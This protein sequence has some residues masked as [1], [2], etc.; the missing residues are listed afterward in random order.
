MFPDHPIRAL[1]L[2][3]MGGL[4]AAQNE[5][6]VR[7]PSGTRVF[8]HSRGDRGAQPFLEAW[9]EADAIYFREGASGKW[10]TSAFNIVSELGWRAPS[11]VEG[12][13]GVIKRRQGEWW[14]LRVNQGHLPHQRASE[15][16]RFDPGPKTWLLHQ[17]LEVQ[18][19]N[20]EVFGTDH[21]ILFG[22]QELDKNRYHLAAILKGGGLTLQGEAP[23]QALYP[24][25]FWGSCITSIDA[26]MAYAYFPMSGHLY[27]YDLDSHSLKNFRVPWTPLA[28]EWM[29]REIQ[30]AESSGKKEFIISAA[31]HPSSPGNCYFLPTPGGQMAFIFKALDVEEERQLAFSDGKSPVIEKVGAILLVSD[32]PNM[33]VELTPPSLTS[34]D[35]WCWSTSSNSLVA[36]DHLK[37]RP[38]HP[39]PRAASQKPTTQK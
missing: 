35:R 17:R 26:R 30:R 28:D 27:G 21:I 6:P 20:F 8:I 25:L 9:Q 34:L 2:F 39:A 29:R 23:I 37:K 33:A 15:V 24:E 22:V 7:K 12:W 11:L 1:L 4:A 14:F 13:K 38:S 32:D 16:Y 18:A 10:F 31:G 19:S 36:M 5:A 3:L